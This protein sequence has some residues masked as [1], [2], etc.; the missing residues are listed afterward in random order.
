MIRMKG[1]RFVSLFLILAMAVC[2]LTGCSLFSMNSKGTM[3]AK[4]DTETIYKHAPSPLDDIVSAVETSSAQTDEEE[5]GGED[6]ELSDEMGAE[7]FNFLSTKASGDKYY[8][9][10]TD[11]EAGSSMFL[12]AFDSEGKNGVRVKLPGSEDSG[13]NQFSVLPNGSILLLINKYD[14]E[15]EAFIW[16]LACCTIEGKEQAE[17][18][19]VWKKEISSEEDFYPGGMV[20]LDKETYLQT[21]A[22]LRVYDNK[23]GKELKKIELPKDFNGNIC[24]SAKGDIIIAGTDDS[25]IAA[26]TLDKEK[27]KFTATKYKAPDFFFTDSVASGSGEYDFYLTK[28]DGIFGFKLD[29]VGPV[30]VMDFLASDLELESTVGCSLLSNGTLV[31][32]YY[33]MDYGTSA[34]LFKKTDGGGEDGKIALSLACS[35]AD[36]SLSK[37]V[38]NFNKSSDKYRIVLLEYPYDED[39]KNTLNMEI[40]AGN[41]PDMICVSGDMPVESYAAKGLFEDLGPL[42][43]KDSEIA[44][45]EYLS[46]VLDAFRID[47]NMYFVTPSFNVIGLFGKKKDFADTKGVTI[48]QI[49]KMMK[50]R[51]IGYDTA[52]GATTREGML[53]WVLFCAME[54]Y[55]DWDAGTCSFG[56][57]SFVDL[58][59]FCARFPGKINYENINWNKYEAAMREGKQL[60]RDGYLYNFDCYMQER[61]GYIGEEVVLMGYPGSGN[62]GPVIQ[63]ELSIAVSKDA[64]DLQGCWEFL[65]RFYQDSYQENIDLAFP[66]SR[67]AMHKMAE[68]ALHPKIHTYTNENG[69]KVSEPETSSVFLNGK[70]IKIPVPSQEDIDTVMNIINSLDMKVSVDSK[71]TGII[72]EE[73]GAFFAGQKSAENTADIIQ[74]RVKV[75]ISETK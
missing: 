47:G 45:K 44:E 59:K 18:K 52:M 43:E 40:A 74:S 8:I 64:A 34:G 25:G 3:M 65:R 23:D 68:K 41:I 15:K 14:G 62:N 32:L 17:L 58:L 26:Y 7:R 20:S 35:F 4:I 71:I 73:A 46:N 33:N 50:E 10:Y 22:G 63:S 39:G 27:D 24:K 60:V 9:M 51:N 48:A 54:E 30:R 16:Q 56:S 13:V 29:G 37:A 38:V 75:Y 19:E 36:M 57:E 12:C 61:Y 21:D 67:K 11:L 42:F 2:S 28:T 66:V 1:S 49:E 69:E 31:L 72:N 55:V 5:D 6:D 70:E 53:S